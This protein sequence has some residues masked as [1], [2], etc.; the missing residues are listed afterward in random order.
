MLN[1][2][3]SFSSGSSNESAPTTSGGSIPLSLGINF[4]ADSVSTGIKS[5]NWPVVRL[6][7]GS[8]SSSS[9]EDDDNFVFVASIDG[10]DRIVVSTKDNATELLMYDCWPFGSSTL[11][12]LPERKVVATSPSVAFDEIEGKPMYNTIMSTLRREVVATSPSVAFDE[13]EGKPMYNTIMSTLISSPVLKPTSITLMDDSSKH[14]S[15]DSYFTLEIVAEV[16]E[17]L[18]PVKRHRMIYSLL[19]ET[20]QKINAL[21]IKAESPAEV[22]GRDTYI[23]IDTDTERGE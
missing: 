23:E 6:M 19:G 2:R 4:G 10:G 13:I 5:L 3:P 11:C 18:T 12:A 17:G 20:M 1:E 8:A 9:D 7:N 16:F 22:H 15:Q 14:A 21:E